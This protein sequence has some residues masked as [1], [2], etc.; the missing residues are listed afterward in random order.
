VQPTGAEDLRREVELLPPVVDDPAAEEALGPAVHLVGDLLG[1]LEKQR[2]LVD[3]QLEVALIVERHGGDLP[4]SVLAVEHPAVGA[5]Q[6]GVG[7]VADAGPGCCIWLG[8]GAGSLNPLALQVDRDLGAHERA[9]PRIL[10]LDPGAWDEAVRVQETER[11]AVMK[12]SRPPLGPLRHHS[13]LLEVEVTK[14]LERSQSLRRVHVG[15]LGLEVVANPD[16]W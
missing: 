2:V 12:A 1:H 9:V 5:R 13:L 16:A 14:G 3:R 4:E 6:Q 15:V 8:S 7:H 11:L 10:D